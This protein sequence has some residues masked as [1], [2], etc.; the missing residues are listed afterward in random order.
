MTRD[1]ALWWWSG[2]QERVHAAATWLHRR[3]LAR[4]AMQYIF[5]QAVGLLT[6]SFVRQHYRFEPDGFLALAPYALLSISGAFLLVEIPQALVATYERQLSRISVRVIDALDN[7]ITSSRRLALATAISVNTAARETLQLIS[8]PPKSGTRG[9][10]Y[11]LTPYAFMFLSDEW[12]SEAKS[13]I[14]A[15]PFPSVVADLAS[16]GPQ[17]RDALLAYTGEVHWILPDPRM[18]GVRVYFRKRETILGFSP[19]FLL[20]RTHK[21]ISWLRAVADKRRQRNLKTY[22]HL[23]EAVP[24]YRLFL[25]ETCILCQEFPPTQHA[26][27][28]PFYRIS[29]NIDP[30]AHFA[31]RLALT[32]WCGAVR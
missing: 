5:A 27:L 9:P 23:T 13:S 11:F 32:F 18:V 22:I 7:T 16:A 8:A 17:L 14:V 25:C 29:T 31:L 28:Q 4:Y 30:D 26:L 2:W 24:G 20:E 1:R 10:I 19:S 15:K 12:L 21:T 6:L 3:R